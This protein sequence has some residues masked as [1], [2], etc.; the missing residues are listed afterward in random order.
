MIAECDGGAIHVH[1][2]VLC[3]GP[4]IVAIPVLGFDFHLYRWPLFGGYKVSLCLGEGVHTFTIKFVFASIESLD[5]R[6]TVDC[7]GAGI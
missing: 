1:Y 2:N 5:V 7:T 4:G 3:K 6:V